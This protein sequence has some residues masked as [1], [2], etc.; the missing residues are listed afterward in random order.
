MIKRILLVFITVFISFGMFAQPS[1]GKLTGKLIIFH[2][3]SLSVPMKELAAAFNKLHPELTIL[4]ESAGSVDCARKITDLQKPCDI[5]ASADYA[6][7]D[8]MLIPAHTDWNIRFVANEMC[9]V[10][11]PKARYASEINKN[12]WFDVLMRK[13]VA[14]G[15]SDPNADPCGYRSL[16][17]IQLAEKYY[18]KPGL[19][20][21]LTAKDQNFIRPKEV[22]L[23]PLLETNSVDYIFLYKSVAIQHDLK[24]LEL[25]AEINL[26][27]PEFTE[28]YSTAVVSI[29]GKEPGQK[30]NIKGEPM[31]YGIT[32]LKDAPN[33]QA[34]LAFVEFLLS[35]D[36]GM[37]IMEKNGQPSV[38]PQK[39]PNFDKLPASLKPF[40]TK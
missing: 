23:I 10:Y 12:N 34:A 19:G 15:R 13:D 29:N 17:T 22:D 6:V 31:I 7:I 27:N 38:I 1:S 32:I 33:K 35:G 26:R 36:K 25:P 4:M 37:R 40:V 28:L 5:M 8:K 18:K 11:T 39:N 2:A 21:R 3:G 9:I 16:M 20:N 14:F 30:V 24:Y